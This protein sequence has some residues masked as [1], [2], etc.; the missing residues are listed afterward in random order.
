M[1][2]N[3]IF[4]QLLA[5]GKV[6]AILEVENRSDGLWQKARIDHGELYTDEW[7][8]VG[9]SN[10]LAPVTTFTT[11]TIK[12]GRPLKYTHIDWKHVDWNKSSRELSAELDVG[13]SVVNQYRWRY[14]HQKVG[15]KKTRHIDWSKVDWS[16]N[17]QQIAGELGI[18]PGSVA[19]YRQRFRKPPSKG[20]KPRVVTKE[21]IEAVDW[22]NTR[23]IAISKQWGV[24]R[25]RVR[26]I[27]LVKNKPRCVLRTTIAL[28]EEVERWLLANKETISGMLAHEVSELCPIDA[29]REIKFR[30]MKKVDIQFVWRKSKQSLA[31]VYDVNWAIPNNI[32]DWIWNRN[33][34]W[35]AVNRWKLQKPKAKYFRRWRIMDEAQFAQ[36]PGLVK[37]VQAEIEKAKKVGVEPKIQELREY[38]FDMV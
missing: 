25:E 12:M 15:T 20:H 32:L 28:H 10:G 35:A 1:S 13:Y 19:S 5:E 18:L 22:V 37:A 29:A 21:M 30:T 33:E 9:A 38:G 36:V 3:Q 11:G 34:H 7:F 2:N 16:K 17:N 23:D 4:Q 8:R 31:E 24:S 6:R 27:R 26:Q 14:G